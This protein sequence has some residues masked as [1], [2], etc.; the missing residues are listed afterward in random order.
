MNRPGAALAGASATIA[1]DA[2]MNPFDG[3]W[4]F[5]LACCFIHHTDKWPHL[6]LI[7]S[8]EAKNAGAQV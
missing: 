7:H 4:S 3:A 8:R 1:S 6:Y 2:L 5:F